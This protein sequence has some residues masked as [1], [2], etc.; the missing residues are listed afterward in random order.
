MVKNC[1]QNFLFFYCTGY[2]EKCQRLCGKFRTAYRTTHVFS[3]KSVQIEKIAGNARV[4]IKS[5]IL[6]K[7]RAIFD[8]FQ[9][10][11][12]KASCK[13]EKISEPLPHQ[14]A[15]AERSWRGVLRVL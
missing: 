10:R 5:R 4:L 2:P 11:T 6:R 13:N 12:Q 9:E 15:P 3:K 8:P 14:A 7:N 1:G